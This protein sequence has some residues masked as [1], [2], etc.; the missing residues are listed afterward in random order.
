MT[1]LG[2]FLKKLSSIGSMLTSGEVPLLINGKP[3]NIKEISLKG[4]GGD[5]YV[6]IKTK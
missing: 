5:Y 1:T 6:D 4:E 3:L 2:S